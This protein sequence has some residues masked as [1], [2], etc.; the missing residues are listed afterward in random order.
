MFD[1]KENFEGERKIAEMLSGL[2][3]MNAPDDFD[4]H[5]RSRIAS[6]RA[7]EGVSLWTANLIRIG[8][9][10]AAAIVLALG[11]YLVFTSLNTEQ[12]YVPA[13]A[14][15][16]PQTQSPAAAQPASDVGTAQEANRATMRP[17]DELIVQN[18]SPTGDNAKTNGAHSVDREAP[19]ARLTGGSTELAVRESKKIFPRGLNPNAKPAANA[20]GVD[21]NARMGVLQIL[22]FIGI[23]ATW[24]S[25]G[26][27]VDSVDAKTIA[28]RSGVRTGDIVEAISGQKVDKQTTF[29]ARFDGN[30]VRV[31]RNGAS[32]QI[33][34]KP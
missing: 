3:R 22:D 11:S 5:V 16:Q 25:D 23:K 19:K 34:F 32:L 30:S 20:K 10:L 26:W 21:P 27:R 24:A 9:P 2:S 4:A 28:E 6:G 13:V 31:R 12:Y 8:V 15:V 14:E 1:E 29:P 18:N 17:S 33:D 7:N